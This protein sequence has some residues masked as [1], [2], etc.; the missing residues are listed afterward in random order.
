MREN[1]LELQSSNASN[2]KSTAGDKHDTERAMTHMEMATLSQQV[3]AEKRL[4]HELE[5][6]ER[7]ATHETVGPGCI[8]QTQRHNLFIGLA[9][10]NMV[11]EGW[12]ITGISVH[13]PLGKELLGLAKGETCSVNGM[14]H[15][16]EQI[17]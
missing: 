11:V 4:L 9:F 6:L 7:Q 2:A 16:V 14:V 1:L 8:V 5:A 17:Y 10:G 3:D 12:P 13:S 15:S